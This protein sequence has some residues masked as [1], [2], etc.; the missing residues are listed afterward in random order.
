MAHRC[1]LQRAGPLQTTRGEMVHVHSFLKSLERE[2]PPGGGRDCPD[3]RE[4]EEKAGNKR[5]FVFPEDVGLGDPAEG[6][7]TGNGFKVET[8]PCSLDH[9]TVPVLSPRKK[10]PSTAFV[11]TRHATAA[12]APAPAP[13]ASAPAPAPAPAP[14]APAPAPAPLPATAAAAAAAAPAPAPPHPFHTLFMH[15]HRIIFV[16]IL[17]RETFCSKKGPYFQS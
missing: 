4:R 16:R 12:P 14:A 17:F 11:F 8:A 7:S 6:C 3:W 13:A 1:A 9:C 5:D 2:A 15:A 10:G